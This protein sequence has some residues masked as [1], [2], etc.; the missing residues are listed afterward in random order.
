MIDLLVNI[1]GIALIGL[2]LW[3]FWF[4]GPR[5]KPIGDSGPIAI[6][7]DD[8]VY[9]PATIEVPA[10]RPVTLR[11]L[12]QDPN[13]SAGQVIFGSLGLS[14]DLPLGKPRDLTLTLDEAGEYAFGCQAGTYRGRLVARPAQQALQ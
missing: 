5:A 4:A 9:T 7:V 3:W 13:P 6:L 8:G 14:G 11:F 10:G 2:I 12:R 1:A